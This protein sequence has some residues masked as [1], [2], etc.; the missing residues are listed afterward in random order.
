MYARH[1]RPQPN[2][3]PAGSVPRENWLL[4]AIEVVR[5]LDDPERAR[6]LAGMGRRPPGGA[7][8]Q[9]RHRQRFAPSRRP[10]R[11]HEPARPV[12]SMDTR[13]DRRNQASA[14]RR[15][16]SRQGRSPDAISTA[17]GLALKNP[18][19]SPYTGR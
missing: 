7:G 18:S 19:K 3:T 6:S 16:S 10:P 17:R 12:R 14:Q 5:K 11:P 8:P 2:R 13:I 1:N 9:R 15:R 4:L